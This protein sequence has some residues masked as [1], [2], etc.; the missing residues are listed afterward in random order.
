MSSIFINGT[1]YAVSTTLA[2]AI[3]IT[4]VTNSNPAVASA[5]NPPADGSIVV[6][7]SGWPILDESVARTANSDSDSFEVEGVDT[8]NTTLYPAG[9]GGGT[10]RVVVGWVPLDQ[11]REVTVSGGEQQYFDYQYVEDPTSRQRQKPTF[12]NATTL[13]L[14]L[15]Y[16]PDK[17]WYS[18]LIAADLAREPVVVRGVLPNGSTMLYYAY[19]SF[20][21]V[22]VGGVNENLQ[23]T[24]TFSLIAD[25]VRYEA[26]Q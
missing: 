24:A 23:N 5:V 14:S 11:V 25:P 17:A 3:P 22:P 18:A 7:N 12:K 19:P 2:A 9:V 21:K 6:L 26:A 15:D 20:N 16:D 4:A 1:Q 8:T 13:T 10:A